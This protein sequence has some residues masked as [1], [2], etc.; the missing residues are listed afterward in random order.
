MMVGGK[1][2]RVVTYNDE[3]SAQGKNPFLRYFAHLYVIVKPGDGEPEF[4]PVS[5]MMGIGGEI[6][7]DQEIALRIFRSISFDDPS[8]P[9]ARSHPRLKANS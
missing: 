5:L 7:S 6:E 4:L 9:K 8:T 2:A 3:T 1:T